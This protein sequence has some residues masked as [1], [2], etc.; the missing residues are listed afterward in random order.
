MSGGVDSFVTALLLKQRGYDVTGVHLELW[1]SG[2]T[3][4][5]ESLCRQLDIKFFRFSGRELFR[6]NVVKPFVEGYLSGRTPNPCALCNQSVKWNLLLQAARSVG[7]EQIATGHYV[8][9][10][11]DGPYHYIHKGIDPN[12]DQSYFLWGLNQEILASALTPL[13]DYTK[14]QVKAY[15]EANG[16]TTLARKKESMGICFLEG[17]DY[18]EFL[19][20]KRSEFVQRSPSVF[21]P[22]DVLDT[23]GK[24]IGKHSGLLNY[25]VGQKRGL[26]LKDGQSLYVAAIYV[27][28]NL[29]VAAEKS[30]LIRLTVEVEG[31]KTVCREDLFAPDVEMKIRGLGLNPSGFI[32]VEE[33]SGGS[34]LVHLTSSAWAV[35]P[36]QPVAFYRDDRLIGGGIV[37]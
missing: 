8:R 24:V 16:F 5:L 9:I 34:L 15:A 2:D 30:E 35:A 21:E 31:V 1:K 14:V 13:G 36:G 33:K 17:I 26:P 32:H 37:R 11:P 28:D 23:T 27:A 6:E 7:V 22:G 18:R 12:K 19:I 29:I 25:T 20:Q 4:A 10:L 3:S